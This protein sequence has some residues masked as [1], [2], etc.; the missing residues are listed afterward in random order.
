MNRPLPAVVPLPTAER[1]DRC[2]APA[3]VRTSFLVGEDLADLFWCGHHFAAYEAKIRE[4]AV[5][6]QM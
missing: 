4:E 5:L 2:N 3:R 1:C 6:V